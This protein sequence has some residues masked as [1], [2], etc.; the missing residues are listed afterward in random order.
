MLNGSA[1]LS[2]VEMAATPAM[3][4]HEFTALEQDCKTQL[5]AV[6]RR[7]AELGNYS[8]VPG[9][10]DRSHIFDEAQ[11]VLARALSCVRV[12]CQEPIDSCIQSFINAF[13]L[14]VRSF[15]CLL[16]CDR[17]S[18]HVE[19]R[20]LCDDPLCYKPNL[21]LYGAFVILQKRN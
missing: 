16:I 14:F 11:R 7:I 4:V 3:S 10:P 1:N 5:Q 19:K 20:V 8:A 12:I 6:S 17:T 18:V 21:V 2:S 15:I 13:V 9:N